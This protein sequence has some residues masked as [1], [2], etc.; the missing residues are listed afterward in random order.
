MNDAGEN[1]GCGKI[2]IKAW[3]ISLL[4]SRGWADRR[5]LAG[6][7]RAALVKQSGGWELGNQPPPFRCFAVCRGL[8]P[9]PLDRHPYPA[10]V[11]RRNQPAIAYNHPTSVAVVVFS[12]CL[13][14]FFWLQVVPRTS[15]GVSSERMRD[16]V[17]GRRE[18][19]GKLGP[20]RSGWCLELGPGI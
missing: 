13:F 17:S 4:G 1:A 8:H 14:F 6:A 15:D 12:S 20:L 16:A 3:N 2:K 9:P 18:G 7:G 10:M 5:W 19:P 11:R